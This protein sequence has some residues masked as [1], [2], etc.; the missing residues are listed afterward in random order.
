MAD[1]EGGKWG[2]Y[3]LPGIL[4]RGGRF[5]LISKKKIFLPEPPFRHLINQNEDLYIIPGENK[6]FQHSYKSPHPW[7]ISSANLCV[8]SSFLDLY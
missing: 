6:K 2:D 4:E 3:P 8:G 1:W 5:F 7:N